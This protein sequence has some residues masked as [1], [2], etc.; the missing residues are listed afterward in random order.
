[1]SEEHNLFDYCHVNTNLDDDYFVGIKS[2]A[3]GI[4]VCFPIGYQLSSDEKILRK[5]IMNLI[6]V[7]SEFN[8][9]DKDNFNLN[10]Y[11][12]NKNISFPINAY[13]EIINQFIEKSSY[14]MEKEIS[15]VKKNRGKINWPQTIKKQKPFLQSNG[16]LVYLNYIVRDNF[17]NENNLIT[18]IHKF[19]VYESF[20]KLGWIFTSYMPEKPKIYKDVKL[21]LGVLNDK[22]AKINNDKDKR[23]FMAMIDIVKYLDTERD[24]KTFYFG[25]YRFEYVWENLIDRTF[26]IKDKDR[27]FPKTHWN[28]R[29]N[30]NKNNSA[31]QPDT[32]MIY[33]DD[34]YVLDAKYYKFGIT[35]NIKDLPNSSSI[36]K[37]ITYGEYIYNNK[38]FRDEKEVYNAFIIPYNSHENEFNSIDYYLNIG[39]ATAEWKIGDYMYEKVQAIILDTRYLMYHYKD[40]DENQMGKLSNVI[41]RNEEL[42]L[43]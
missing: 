38:D 32:I 41:K 4:K 13:I 34:I 12:Y 11:N 2:D 18:Q 43:N 24:K 30:E 26:G 8:K 1:M 22:F 23:L 36:N 35:G 27:Y 29:T 14:Y 16:S 33:N 37:Q 40:N 15:Y 3:N 21:F 7:L 19:C 42:S 5:D 17:N 31:L 39:E 25:T 6:S 20:Y 9:I 10:Y 28:L